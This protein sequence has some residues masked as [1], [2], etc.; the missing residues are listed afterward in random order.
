MKIPYF[1][2]DDL[3][4]PI[5]QE[6]LKAFE[7]VLDSNWFILGEKVKTFEQEFAEFCG[8]KNCVGVANGLDALILILE[9]YKQLGFMKNGD[10]VLVPSNTYIASILAISR[11]GLTP[12]LVEPDINTYLIDENLIEQKITSKTKAI[13]PV[14]LYGRLCNMIAIN[15]IAKKYNLKVIEDCA[16]SHGASINGIKCGN[17]GDAAGFSFYPGKNLGALG[18]GGAV[19]TNDEELAQTIIALRNYGSH[20]KYENIYQGINSRLDEVQA[21]FLS[22]KLKNLN[23][24]NQKRRKIAQYYI[25][26]INSDLIRLPYTKFTNVLDLE[27]HVWHVF[28]IRVAKRERFQNYLLQNGIQ[29]VIHYPIPPHKQQAYAEWNNDSYPVSEKIHEEIISLPISPVI[30]DIQSKTVVDIVNTYQKEFG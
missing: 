24:D 7:E 5:K 16:Q 11:A 21:A 19:T 25:D 30:S 14:H 4:K 18:D 15:S 17:L 29:T 10:E 28:A 2:F 13:L 20:K 12:V 9:G 3:H 26:H 23:T 27:D 1:S 8:V 6:L 22:V